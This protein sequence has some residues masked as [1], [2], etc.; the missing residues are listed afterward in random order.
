M[1][2]QY[3]DGQYPLRFEEI[4]KIIGATSNYRDKLILET[5]YYC[6]MRRFE[7]CNMK[8]TDI[9]FDRG[10]IKV[11]GKFGKDAMIPVNSLF[12]QY[13]NDLKRFIGQRKEGY[14]FESNRN[15]KLEKSRI[16]Q[17]LAQITLKNKFTNPNPTKKYINPHSFRH[18]LARHLK[19]QRLPIEFIQN[20][21][22]HASMK[23]TFDVY[24]KLSLDEMEKVARRFTG[25]IVEEK[26]LR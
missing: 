5:L 2:K 4:E 6:G 24:G 20:Y 9:D 7:V 19:D 8:I 26:L 11:V 13:L 16:N 18:S 12:P 14:V 1:S 25:Q 15:K 23:T 3:D 21:L 17:I 10:R 22:R